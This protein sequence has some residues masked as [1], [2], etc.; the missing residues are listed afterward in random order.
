[1]SRQV[2]G[3]NNR[4][5]TVKLIRREYQKLSNRKRDRA[6]KLVHK[7]RAYDR[8]VIQDEQI[9]GWQKGRFGRQVQRSCLGLVKAKLRLLP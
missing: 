3:S 4:Y 5:K 2:K 9:A 7:F 6:N 1:M 8:I